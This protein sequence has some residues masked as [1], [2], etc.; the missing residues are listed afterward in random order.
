MTVTEHVTSASREESRE[1]LPPPSA[2]YLTAHWKKDVATAIGAFTTEFVD[3]QHLEGDFPGGAG[4]LHFRFTMD[5][6][7]I[8]RLVIES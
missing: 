1:E 6:A 5:G 2:T 4:D 3:V 7:L 8:C